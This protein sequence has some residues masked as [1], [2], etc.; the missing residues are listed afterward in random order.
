MTWEK[1]ESQNSEFKKG[2]KFILEFGK[3]RRMFGEFEIAGTDL[4]VRKDL[5]EKLTPYTP[6]AQPNLQST[7][8]QLA[9]DT[10]S[11]QAAIDAAIKATDDW[12]GGYSITRANMIEKELNNLPPAQHEKICINLNEPIKVKL[13]EWGKE[14]FYHQYDRANEII[15]REVCKPSLPKED[16]NGYTEFQLW[17]FIELYGTHMGMTLPNVIEPLEIVYD[18]RCEE[19]RDDG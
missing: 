3:E 19:R 9:T 11:R 8:N 5:L 15:G 14:I 18:A 12:D 2:D 7:C 1:S 17:E 6:T 13:T 16:E 4:Y 10:I